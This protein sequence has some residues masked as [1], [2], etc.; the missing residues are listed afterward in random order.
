MSIKQECVLEGSIL[1][2]SENKHVKKTT[3]LQ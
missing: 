1:F 3:E 2:P